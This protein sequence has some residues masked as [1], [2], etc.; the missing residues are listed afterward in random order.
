MYEIKYLIPLPT[1]AT[2]TRYSLEGNNLV[3]TATGVVESVTSERLSVA[4]AE[5]KDCLG[6]KN[7]D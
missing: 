7:E 1:K 4:L 2:N 5:L 6:S 3:I